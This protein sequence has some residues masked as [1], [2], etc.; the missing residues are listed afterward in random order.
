LTLCCH[1]LVIEDAAPTQVK[2]IAKSVKILEGINLK[3][4]KIRSYVKLLTNGKKKHF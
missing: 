1:K 3:Y 4:N 2:T